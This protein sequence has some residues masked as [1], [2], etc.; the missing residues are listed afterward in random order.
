MKVWWGGEKM[1]N[2]R[3]GRRDEEGSKWEKNVFEGRKGRVN[4]TEVWREEEDERGW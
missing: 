2:E 4:R 3:E 1:E